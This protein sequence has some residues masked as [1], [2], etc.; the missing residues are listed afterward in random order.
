MVEKIFTE[1]PKSVNETYFEHMAQSFTF[2]A[3]MIAGGL[4]CFLHGI[5]PCI[6]EK[7]GSN[8]IRKLHNR[9]V[10]NRI[11]KK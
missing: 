2:G 4:A 5:L 1:H 6:C 3:K 8:T 9:M 11:K 7:T 10:E